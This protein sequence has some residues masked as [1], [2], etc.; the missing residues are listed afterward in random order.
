MTRVIEY[1]GM[2]AA[3]A[4]DTR[5]AVIEDLRIRGYSILENV[6][7]NDECRAWAEKLDRLNAMQNGQYGIERLAE[8]GEGGTLRGMLR[9]NPD[10]LALVRHPRTWPFVERVIGASA[11]LHLQNGIVVEPH[12]EHHQAAFHRDFA[13]DFV[14]DKVLSLNVFFAIDDFTSETGATWWVP[15]THR[16]TEFPTLRYL[17]TNAVQIEMRAGSVVLF[18]SLI[19]HR[20]GE[21]RSAAPRRAIN[22]QYTRPFIK[23]QMDYPVLL[24]DAVDP[25][26]PLAQT[27]GFWSVP[28]RSVEEFRVNPERRTYRRGQG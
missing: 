20:A 5:D 24:R 9:E 12:C 6:L 3:P 8:L 10:F 23:Q 19:V 27:L 18:D 2:T 13:K 7:S 26:S 21:N 16:V 28:P 25:E 4:Q 11:I 17:E 15:F 22:H 1:V 14:A